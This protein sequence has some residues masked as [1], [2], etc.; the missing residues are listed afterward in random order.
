MKINDIY[1]HYRIMPNLQLH[2]LRVGAV[3]AEICDH[4]P[5]V[6]LDK[7]AVVA[8]ALLHDLGNILKFD[9]TRFPQFLEPKGLRYWEQVQ[10]DFRERYGDN[11][12]VATELIL[13]ELH[14]SPRV[15]ELVQA[16]QFRLACENQVS[17]DFGRKICAYSDMR[18][19]P[20]GIVA[21]VSR[22]DE[23]HKRY[24]G[25][26]VGDTASDHQQKRQCLIQIEN[27]LFSQMDITP[28]YLTNEQLNGT[29][30]ALKNFVVPTSSV[31]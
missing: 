24:H 11:E 7:T 27:Q 26:A 10:A 30:E 29:I 1:H 20:H 18:V 15:K 19:D 22:I 23:A 6:S 4:L 9:L 16:V 17:S 21:L 13:E 14:V 3:A 8:A 25:T 31:G 28:D 2:M 12:K 5:T